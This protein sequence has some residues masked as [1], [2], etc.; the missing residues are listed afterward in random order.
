MA[1]EG[2]R[3]LT[4]FVSIAGLSTVVAVA[5]A[6]IA[7]I[8]YGS[9]SLVV[10]S[11]VVTFEALILAIYQTIFVDRI[12]HTRLVTG[13]VEKF[14]RLLSVAADIIEYKYMN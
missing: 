5:A 8:E 11:L 1:L 14:A 13:D 4:V 10:F 12:I 6:I 3:K 9:N 7:S 2:S